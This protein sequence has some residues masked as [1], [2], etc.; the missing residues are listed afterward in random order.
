MRGSSSLRSR[1]EWSRRC[2]A[3]SNSSSYRIF[4][5]LI[6]ILF[7]FFLHDLAEEEVDKLLEPITQKIKARYPHFEGP[8]TVEQSV[9]DV[10]TLIDQISIENSGSFVHR[11]GR[12]GDSV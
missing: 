9:R 8:I 10:L 2:Q 3:V 1:R 4:V 12:D 6:A 5:L 11:D 7:D